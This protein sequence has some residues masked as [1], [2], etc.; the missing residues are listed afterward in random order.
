MINA[1]AVL[2]YA[3]AMREGGPMRLLLVRIALVF[4]V[5]EQLWTGVWSLL[6]P[7]HF[8]DTFPLPGHPWQAWQPSYNEHLLRD[9][10]ALNLVLALLFGVAA[11]TMDRLMTRVALVA[12]LVF[13]V[14]HLIFHLNHLAGLPTVDAVAQ[15][16]SLAIG[17]AAPLVLLWLTRGMPARPSQ[18]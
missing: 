6:W 7:R 14:P 4:G 10:G 2:V 5:L 17:V 13:G 3:D 9:F 15:V 12:Y 18:P 16:T 1:G 11:Y 8:Y